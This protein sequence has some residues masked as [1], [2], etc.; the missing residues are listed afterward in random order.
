M[1]D[2][3]RAFLYCIWNNDQYM[4]PH[5]FLFLLLLSLT[6]CRYSQSN[7][8]SVQ[9]IKKDTVF[10]TTLAKD[11]NGI[12]NIKVQGEVDDS[13]IINYRFFGKG[14]IDTTFRQDWYSKEVAIQYYSYKAKKGFLHI[15][16][17]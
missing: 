7:H 14:K 13:I 17:D 16:F 10:K 12:I 9:D 1:P 8:F 11:P 6:A 2:K 5:F 4:K 3:A 15:S